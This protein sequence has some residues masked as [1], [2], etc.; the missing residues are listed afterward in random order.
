MSLCLVNNSSLS[1]LCYFYIVRVMQTIL[2]IMVCK[3]LIRQCNILSKNMKYVHFFYFL[4]W[5]CKVSTN[6]IF[7]VHS[8]CNVI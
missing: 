7:V 2:G 6:I 5:F 1:E 4:I 3:S 8:T